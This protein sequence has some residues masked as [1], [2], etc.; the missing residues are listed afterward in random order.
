LFLGPNATLSSELKIGDRLPPWAEGQVDIHHINTGKGES[1]FFILPDGTT[2]LV[3][4]GAALQAKPWAADPKPDGARAPGEW[5][6]KYISRVQPARP[7][8]TLDYVLLTHFHWDHMGGVTSAMK[9][10]ATGNYRLS[11]ITEVAEHIPFGKLIDRNWPHYNWPEPLDDEKMKN[12]RQFVDW[13]IKHRGLFVEQFAVG[14]NS[15][16]VLKQRPDKYP[17]FEIR[18]LAANGQVWTGVGSTVRN[19]FPALRDLARA[20]YP[21][22]NKCSIAF[23]LS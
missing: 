12:Y 2:L 3:D 23:R 21:S 10:S 11:G 9:K 6:A 22:E 17:D 20:E 5:I 7:V 14:K 13:Q 16:L 18:N 8:P 15:Q 19:H 4:A 1:S